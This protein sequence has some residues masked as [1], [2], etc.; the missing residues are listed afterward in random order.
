VK[1][2]EARHPELLALLRAHGLSAAVAARVARVGAIL[3]RRSV[4]TAA[5]VGTTLDLAT[6]RPIG[7]TLTGQ[8]DR[9]DFAFQFAAFRPGRR[10]AQLHTHLG[11]SSF[12]DLDVGMLLEHPALRTLVVVGEDR[13][14]YLLSKRTGPPSVSAIEGVVRWNEI[15]DAMAAA[16]ETLIAQGRLS[17]AAAR[18]EEIHETMVRLA[19][20]LHLR[21]DDLELLR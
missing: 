7:P 1:S 8:A 19:G 5:E 18:V 20:E 11:S 15:W 2:G 13:H 9:V 17:E 21:Y 10:Y 3:H 12:S 6:G 16:N 4:E 14:W